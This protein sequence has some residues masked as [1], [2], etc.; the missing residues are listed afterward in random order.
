MSL[1]FDLSV[2]S[3]RLQKTYKV[4]R[5]DW[6]RLIERLKKVVR[7]S[8]TMAEYAAMTKDK[9]SR[10]KDA[11]A[12]VGGELDGGSRKKVLTRQ[13]V[14]LDVDYATADFAQLWMK[15]W[16][17]R[18]VFYPTHSSTPDKPRYRLII[19]LTEP[20]PAEQYQ[21]IARMI[22]CKMGMELFDDTTYEPQRIMYWPS[23]PKDAP[24]DL[25]ICAG[26]VLSPGEVLA[27]YKDWR[28]VAEWPFSARS[29]QVRHRTEKK[30]QAVVEKRG[31]VG[32]FVRAWPIEECIAEF[33]P[34][35]V[36]GAVPGRYTYAPGSTANGV[37]IYDG[38]YSFSHHD[39]DPASG[40]ECN[41]F[42]LVRL[43]RFKSL[44]E[45]VKPGTAITQRPSYKKMIDFAL[46]DDRTL[47]QLQQEQA[48]EAE[49]TAAA[50]DDESGEG[51]QD[52]TAWEKKLERDRTGWPTSS[53]RNI[54]VIL[55][56]DPKFAG[57]FGYDEFA[58]KEVALGDL[59]W[60]KVGRMDA[61]LRDIDDAEIR[62]WLG[63]KYH[64]TGKDKVWDCVQHECHSR[65]FH[66]IKKYLEGLVWDGMP[67]IDTVL[68]DYFGC[69]D[70]GYIRAITRKTFLAA[71]MRIYKPGAQF[72]TMLTLKGPQGC[73]KSS[74]FRK[75]SKGWFSDS[76]K[77]I[78]TK[79][80]LEGL[81]GVWI[82]EMGELSALRKADAEVIKSFL[83]GTVDRFRAAYGRR[84]IEYPRQCIFV[85]TTNECEF[86][87]DRT[88][89]RRFWIAEVPKDAQPKKDV[90]A[91]KEEEI[92]QMW[93]EAKH[94]YDSHVETVVLTPKLAQQA[95]DIQ[96]QYL[97]DDPRAPKIR[98]YL[99]RL[100]PEDWNKMS[101]VDRQD[102]L[103][104]E[105]E[106]TVRRTRVCAVEIWCEALGHGSTEHMKRFDAIEINQILD[107][108][109]DWT[110]AKSSI[111]FPIYGKAKAFIRS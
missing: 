102:W 4:Q 43:H 58:R 81:Q 41:A 56:N 77:D 38:Q 87:R 10:A 35:Y 45:D 8:E 67:R 107:S 47:A 69:E 108:L 57:K 5:W 28:D 17:K 19:P 11:G 78:K 32:A 97:Q 49:E 83:S 100:L 85:A 66:P 52:D 46:Q 73:G 21:P 34:D 82:I 95:L 63:K 23:V 50:F 105:E 60:R 48:A 27:M 91:I 16:N 79:D 6:E 9:K 92:D 96:E 25:A 7:T 13:L 51:G 62:L 12:F 104:S 74:F 39:T 94:L 90:F 1:S 40:V 3:S 42:D 68:I 53:Y 75:L 106:G 93:A 84:T 55:A 101:L 22:A 18:S 109:P 65:S 30:M 70:C 59:P 36:P 20:V 2:G 61:A 29:E 33:V 76:L 99:D 26:P 14:C 103:A 89:N 72:D 110:R 64:I 54:E 37:V 88:G 15:T 80:A 24:Y 44:D 31:V 86:L 111:R 98:E 71:V